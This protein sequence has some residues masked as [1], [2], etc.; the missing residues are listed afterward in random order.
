VLPH[1]EWQHPDSHVSRVLPVRERVAVVVETGHAEQCRDLLRGATFDE[2]AVEPV[3]FPHYTALVIAQAPAQW[4]DFPGLTWNGFTLARTASM[5]TAACYEQRG[6]SLERAG[7]RDEAMRCF[8][9]AFETFP[10]IPANL[11]MLAAR[12]HEAAAARL[13]ALKPEHETPC[14]FW[15][16]IELVGYTLIP[17]RLVPGET[18]TL[19]LVWALEGEMPNDCLP[20][21]V[22][23]VDADGGRAGRIRFQADHSVA[24]PV[25]PGATVPRSLV[26]D[27]CTFAVPSGCEGRQ[28]AV[29]LG[30]LHWENE[31]KRLRPR[32]QLPR[33]DRA[34]ELGVVEV[35]PSSG[36]SAA[37]AGASSM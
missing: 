6:E 36:E 23:F 25:A 31:G 4:R 34:V 28:L 30:A 8:E 14:R 19:R 18:A 11:E 32:T 5:A 26:L 22:H 10:G 17:S 35:A 3:E 37:P 15:P 13:R 16:S 24:F 20:V 21:F 33:A 9:R 29:R 1:Y 27:E 7:R 12:G 2:V